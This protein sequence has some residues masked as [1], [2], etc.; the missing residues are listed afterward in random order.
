[1]TL[2]GNSADLPGKQKSNLSSY[3]QVGLSFF[4][5][6]ILFG[7]AALFLILFLLGGSTQFGFVLDS[8]IF[9]TLGLVS[10]AMGLLVLPSGISALYR[11]RNCKLPAWLDHDSHTARIFN[12]IA[13]PLLVIILAAGAM[14]EGLDNASPFILSFLGILAISIPVLML[15][16]FGSKGLDGGSPQRKLGLLAF[17]LTITPA[18]I[19]FA[20]IFALM[21][22]VA[23]FMLWA[24][25]KPELLDGL[26]SLWMQLSVAGADPANLMEIIQPYLTQPVTVFWILAAI[27]L[28]VPLI[29]EIFKTTGIWLFAN[30]D[31]TPAQGYTAGLFSG[32]GLALMEGLFNLASVNDGQTWLFLV[33]G[34]IG[35]SLMHIL[36]GGLI[37]WGLASS[38]RV[39]KPI[40]YLVSFL[41]SLLIHGLWN[42]LALSGAFLPF[43]LPPDRFPTA[44]QSVL[45]LLPLFV[46]GLLL[47]AAFISFTLMVRDQSHREEALA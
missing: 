43:F 2:Y 28:F 3:F 9:I 12:Q 4:A 25:E 36:T 34:R 24:S 21:F 42:A 10:L 16:S 15:I 11:I 41:V 46:L 29:E 37:G 18:I 23:G 14:V 31:L 32:A 47:L 38:W 8:N 17:G 40:K 5:S 30:R 26:T 19:L 33:I 45:Y 44:T 20:E 7:Q 39:G 35:S 1:M 22:G 13:L 27:S 6:L